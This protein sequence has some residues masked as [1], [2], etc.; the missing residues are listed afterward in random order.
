MAPTTF[1]YF[2]VRIPRIFIKYC[3]KDLGKLTQAIKGV[4][5]CL[6]Q[7]FKNKDGDERDCH[8]KVLKVLESDKNSDKP[9]DDPKYCILRLE[10]EE[11]LFQPLITA[12]G[13][14]FVGMNPYQVRGGGII[15]AL[16]KQKEEGVV[17]AVKQLQ[18]PGG[19]TVNDQDD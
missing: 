14:I 9:K 8:F 6:T 10:V 16:K 4:N 15:A 3:N 12:G 11:L 19:E 17:A 2:T 18:Q 7:T 13:E 1:R 5:A